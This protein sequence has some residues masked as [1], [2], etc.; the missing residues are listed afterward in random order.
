VEGRAVSAGFEETPA[1]WERAD[2][3]C[4]KSFYDHFL[5][6]PTFS[7]SR[8]Y[9]GSK[10]CRTIDYLSLGGMGLSRLP[11][12]GRYTSHEG[13][14]DETIPP[15]GRE[16]INWVVREGSFAN[17]CS[18]CSPIKF[19]KE[20]VGCLLSVVEDTVSTSK[21]CFLHWSCKSSNDFLEEKEL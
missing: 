3:V 8:P 1:N 4:S 6:N 15:V 10:E 5:P 11:P 2:I 12:G 17:I 13:P 7:F 20:T 21:L 9:I 19:S 18:P 16:Q 14:C